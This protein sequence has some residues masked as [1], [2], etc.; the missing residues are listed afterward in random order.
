M[1]VHF[2]LYLRSYPKF[3]LEIE[4]KWSILYKGFTFFWYF[5]LRLVM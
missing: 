2:F 4:P 1:T 3:F 5:L